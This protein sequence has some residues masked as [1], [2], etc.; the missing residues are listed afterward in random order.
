MLQQRTI[1]DYE[2]DWS[3]E[4][5]NSRLQSSRLELNKSLAYALL[6]ITLGIVFLFSGVGKFVAGVDN[7]A[8]DQTQQFSG[9]L[10]AFLVNSFFHVLPFLE[11]AV[12]VLLIFGVMNLIVLTASGL[13]LIVL[14]LGTVIKGD[15][16]TTAHNVVYMTVNSSLLWLASQDRFSLGRLWRKGVSSSTREIT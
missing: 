2:R 6:R 9:K 5:P 15:F 11:V 10:P 1:S 16:G 12:G 8:A 13:L 7:L 4:Q 3:L 14:T